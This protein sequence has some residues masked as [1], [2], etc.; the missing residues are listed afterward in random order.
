MGDLRSSRREV[1]ALGGM[2]AF[3]GCSTTGSVVDRFVDPH[4]HNEDA[5]VAEL[6]G[7]W[8]IVGADV[9]RT[10]A[11]GV[12]PPGPDA[13]VRRL[14]H[15]GEHFED[16][17]VLDPERAFAGVDEMERDGEEPFSGTV[18]LE[19]HGS[20]RVAWRNEGGGAAPRAVR[21]SVVFESREHAIYAVD[22][23]DGSVYWRNATAG[24][25][26]LPLGDTLYSA[27]REGSIVALDAA[28]GEQL[29]TSEVDRPRS[30]P[31]AF[32]EEADALLLAYGNGGGG[33]FYCFEPDSGEVRWRY[34]DVGESYALAVT[35]GRRGFTVGTD[36]TLH[37]VD[38][39][40]GEGLW[41]YAFRRDSYQR[42]AVA[43]GTV[44]ATG[45]NDDLLVALDAETGVEQWR[46]P[47]DVGTP[48]SPTVAGDHVLLR[49]NLPDTENHLHVLD[50]ET[51]RL[52]YGFES[53]RIRLSTS[54]QPVVTADAAYLVGSEPHTRG[55]S[56]YEIR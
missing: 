42:P 3:A 30:M 23:D 45:T 25:V 22:A 40:T 4:T 51:G 53:P 44:Y 21:G 5:P 26:A 12:S 34:D 16:Q 9:R 50:R 46:V 32:A 48:S 6:T 8:P 19:R 1:V 38:L 35:D 39:E 37:A 49:A 47:L 56:L 27:G 13:T 7:P 2:L 20:S 33:T 14:S 55:A 41:T 18:A 43:D 15:L 36:G 17:V 54:V 31:F 11:T 28:T 29:W 52:E 24:F 10:G